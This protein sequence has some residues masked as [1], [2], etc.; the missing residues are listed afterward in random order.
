MWSVPR[1]PSKARSSR[2]GF[3]L[4]EVMVALVIAV[5]LGAGLVRFFAGVRGEAQRSREQF[6]AW[7]VARAVLGAVPSGGAV[8]PGTTVGA[9]GAFSWRLEASPMAAALAVVPSPA[10]DLGGG[11]TPSPPALP[12]RLRVDV[13]GPRGGSARLETIRL[14]TGGGGG[15]DGL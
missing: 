15:G 14:A 4:I 5:I 10:D 2:R 8:A 1:N 11:D 9:T 7:T 6:D 12:M 13:T 3:T